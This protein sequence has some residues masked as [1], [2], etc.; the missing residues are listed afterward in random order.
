LDL[1]P[2]VI[3]KLPAKSFKQVQELF[4]ELVLEQAGEWES[5]QVLELALEQ[6]RGQ[7]LV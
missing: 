5:V 1:V 2:N 3:L 7:V 4:E 6:V